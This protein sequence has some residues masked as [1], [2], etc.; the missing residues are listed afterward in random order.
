MC[1]AE[2]QPTS[3]DEMSLEWLRKTQ[4]SLRLQGSLLYS[5]LGA[6]AMLQALFWNLW[7]SKA[8][9]VDKE[10]VDSWTDCHTNCQVFR[11]TIRPLFAY[12][13]EHIK[14]TE[15]KP[16]ADC[17]DL[18]EWWVYI[19]RMLYCWGGER[20]NVNNQGLKVP[21]MWQFLAAIPI[22]AFIYWREK[23]CH[24]R[25]KLER[26]R[27]IVSAAIYFATVLFLYYY[28][29]QSIFWR[30]LYFQSRFSHGACRLS[31]HFIQ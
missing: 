30:Y 27:K 12:V 1:R 22:F 15:D 17:T 8:H 29:S 26:G 28:Y 6:Y 7:Y 2:N 31:S 4:T 18:T 9:L 21:E 25:G 24:T 5:P 14:D 23:N 19:F 10:P 16:D 13:M 3:N 11:E 20:L